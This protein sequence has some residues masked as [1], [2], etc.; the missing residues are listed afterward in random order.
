MRLHRHRSGSGFTLI[1][2][3]VTLAI[4]GVLATIALPLTEVAV[5]R[6]KEQG[7]RTALRQIREALDAYK[8]ASD[9]GRIRK[10]ADES[11]YP[12]TLQILMDGV[13]DLKS[14]RRAKIYF[15]RGVPRDPMNSD[16]LLSPQD[17][18]GIRS[19]ASSHDNP[20]QGRD[21]FDVYSLSKNTGLNGIPYREW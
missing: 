10:S 13:D 1:E 15:L 8:Q 7:L 20:A 14:P 16:S 11:G 17:T 4:I 5:Q 12:P 2:L 9:D 18:W 21:V 3:M 19:Y 6:S